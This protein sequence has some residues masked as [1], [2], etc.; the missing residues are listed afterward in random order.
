MK[1]CM[2]ARVHMMTRKVLPWH[3]SSKIMIGLLMAASAVMLH[4]LHVPAHG[5]HM[6][7]MGSVMSGKEEGCSS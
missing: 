5:S 3:Q 1:Q 4:V 6:H 7:S 2:H